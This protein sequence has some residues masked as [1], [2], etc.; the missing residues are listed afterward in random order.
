MFGNA[1][2]RW[3]RRA[4]ARAALAV[5]LVLTA[6]AQTYERY[7]LTE[8]E[9]NALPEEAQAHYSAAV[10]ALDHVNPQDALAELRQA[11][12]LAP[13]HT[14]LQFALGDLAHDQASAASRR[15]QRPEN[16]L[17]LAR[18]AYDRVIN[19]PAATPE[20]Q[21]RAQRLIASIEREMEEAP[22]IE[23]SRRQLGDIFVRAYALE[24]DWYQARRT[25]GDRTPAVLT[26]TG[27]GDPITRSEVVLIDEGGALYRRQLLA[28]GS[29]GWAP[30]LDENGNQIY[31]DSVPG[32]I[33]KEPRPEFFQGIGSAAEPAMAL[34][35]ESGRVSPAAGDLRSLS[36]TSVASTL[37]E[38]APLDA[39]TLASPEMA[40]PETESA[41]E[42][43]PV[44]TAAAGAATAESEAE[45]GSLLPSAE[46]LPPTP[47][48]AAA[49]SG[50]APFA[51]P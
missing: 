48:E 43:A 47:S 6:P 32:V 37:P 46:P 20:E 51:I 9:F 40:A 35:A 41:E 30:Y 2:A 21:R 39:E 50:E 4:V 42:I 5:G 26:W 36:P 19:N 14:A 31:A 18:E 16:Y 28:W 22:A 8:A 24:Q 49:A 44:F 12:E 25:A 7:L 34:P 1:E 10:A 23:Q 11:A 15:R 38:P 27:P 17:V 29:V 3:L 45:G 33:V 13:D